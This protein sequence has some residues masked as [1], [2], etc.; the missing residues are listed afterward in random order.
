MIYRPM[1]LNP[2]PEEIITD[3][4]PAYIEFKRKMDKEL[5]GF[6]RWPAA[7]QTG[8][9]KKKCPQVWQRISTDMK[10]EM[11]ICCGTEDTLKGA[12]SNLFDCEEN[13]DVLFNHPT[14]VQLRE[15]L[16]DSEAEPPDM[17]KNCNLIGEPGW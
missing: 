16:L 12:N 11:D 7:I 8:K 17:C 4:L 5:P 3:T 1:G 9:V 10:G 15:Q 13:P 14:L 2:N 6:A